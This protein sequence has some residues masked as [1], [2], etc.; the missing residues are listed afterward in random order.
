MIL[1]VNQ[2]VDPENRV[3]KFFGDVKTVKVT[4]IKNRVVTLSRD[5]EF[6][7]YG[8]ERSGVRVDLE[9]TEDPLDVFFGNDAGDAALFNRHD[10]AMANKSY[11]KDGVKK[12]WPIKV[13]F[14]EFNNGEFLYKY[15]LKDQEV[16]L[17]NDEGQTIDNI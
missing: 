2:T 7:T 3:W 10:F 1:K 12:S 17:L 15:T 8:K 13:L 6:G 11:I 4:K 14:V 9:N 16:Y 5:D